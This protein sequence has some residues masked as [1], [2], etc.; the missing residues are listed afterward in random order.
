MSALWWGHLG[1]CLSVMD[2]WYGNRKHQLDA[3]EVFMQH[4]KQV[5]LDLLKLPQN[6]FLKNYKEAQQ[7][8]LG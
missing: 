3:E 8:K 6:Y 7:K 2:M 4:I 1:A 5:I